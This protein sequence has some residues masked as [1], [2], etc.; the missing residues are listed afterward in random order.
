MAET[1]KIT[2]V[3]PASVH[4]KFKKKVAKNKSSIQKTLAHCIKD[5]LK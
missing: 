2:I 4:A 5:Y 3:V 1:K